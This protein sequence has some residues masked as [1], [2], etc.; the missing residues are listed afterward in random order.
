MYLKPFFKGIDGNKDG[1]LQKTE[2]ENFLAVVAKMTQDHGLLAIKA[3]GSGDVSSTHVMWK[4]TSAILRYRRR[5]PT[6]RM[7]MW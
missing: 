3:G 1:T 7:C 4:E 2:W 6:R 5:S